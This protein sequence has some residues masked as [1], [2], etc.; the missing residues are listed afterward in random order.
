MEN[1]SATLPRTVGFWGTALFPVNGMIGSG[2]FAMPAILVA[3]VGNFA[4]WMMLLG[5]LLILPLAWVFAALAM[6]FD[7]HGGPVLYANA[8]FGKFFGFQ[9]GWMRYAS[10]VVAVAANTH[11]AIAYLA[12]LFPVL[13]D[14]LIGSAA[15]IAFIAFVTIINLVGMRASVGA[16]GLM[17][18]VKLAPLAVLVVWGLATRDPAIGFSLPEFSDFESVVLL[19]F[20]AYMA[21]ENGNFPAGE[22]KNPRRTIPMALM[23]TLAAVA[24]FYMAVIWAY[25]AIAPDAGGGESALAA[26]AEAVSGQ[27]GVIVISLA[28]AFSVAANILNGGIVVPRMT[29]GMAEQGSLPVAFAHVSPRFLTPDVSVLFYGGAAILFSLWGGFAALAVASTLSRLVMYLLSALALPVLERRDGDKAP[30]WHLPAAVLA[31]IATVWVS[32]HASAEAYQMLGLIFVVGTGL[33]YFA[34][35]QNAAADA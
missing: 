3:A 32:T 1:K 5:A 31:V 11:V 6:R 13:E 10:A 18:V 16:L 20:Y 26:A 23:T 7:G 27:A 25:L 14:P 12:V 24:L 22:L 33:Y 30:W 4:P 8:A 2:I 29:F 28:A 9:S 21:F 34:A 15:V 19:T 35:R 17:T